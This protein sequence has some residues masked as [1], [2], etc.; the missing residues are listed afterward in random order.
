[1]HGCR[2][3]GERRKVEKSFRRSSRPSTAALSSCWELG[4]SEVHLKRPIQLS[5]PNFHLDPLHRGS[6]VTFEVMATDALPQHT[7]TPP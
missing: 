3:A 5:S 7:P 6:S 4:G 1:M 2:V